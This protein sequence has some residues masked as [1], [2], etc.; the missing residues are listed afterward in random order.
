MITFV[1]SLSSLSPDADSFAPTTTCATLLRALAAAL[2]RAIDYKVKRFDGNDRAWYD[3]G[4][5]ELVSYAR[6]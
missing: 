3:E 2:D 5:S 1:L 6:C 4:E